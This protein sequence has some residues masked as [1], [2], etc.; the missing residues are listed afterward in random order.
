MF[1]LSLSL[2]GLYHL[3]CF[4]PIVV[5]QRESDHTWLRIMH[6]AP[7]VGSVHDSNFTSRWVPHPIHSSQV[8]ATINLWI[9]LLTF[10]LGHNP[11]DVRPHVDVYPEE[12]RVL[13]KLLRT[14]ERQQAFLR[15]HSFDSAAGRGAGGLLLANRGAV[16]SLIFFFGVRKCIR[17]I[18]IFKRLNNPYLQGAPAGFSPVLAPDV[19]LVQVK[20]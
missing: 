15:A 11:G 1:V 10:G 19:F 5:A 7:I 4:I 6:L 12:I 3:S 8:E 14:C 20:V 18:G 13:A 16:Q 2:A 9:S 17:S